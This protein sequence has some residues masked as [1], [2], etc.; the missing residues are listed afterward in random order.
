M[1]YNQNIHQHEFE[2]STVTK[3]GDYG[4]IGYNFIQSLGGPL[5]AAEME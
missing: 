1:L 2:K 4:N 5:V 3:K